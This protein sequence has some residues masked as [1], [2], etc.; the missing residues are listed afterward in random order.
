MI[1]FQHIIGR[2]ALFCR[3]IRNIMIIILII[4]AFFSLL[5]GDELAPAYP[6]SLQTVLEKRDSLAE[7][8][9]PDSILEQVSSDLFS[10]IERGRAYLKSG[11]LDDARA[12]FT[13]ALFSKSAWAKC[14]AHI[15]LG[16]CYRKMELHSLDAICEYRLAIQ[17]DST[18]CEAL[19]KLAMTQYRSIKA[20]TLSFCHPRESGGPE[21]LLKNLD[22]RF[23]GNDIVCPSRLK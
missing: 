1:I 2:N 4:S 22:S 3:L 20:T 18:S 14:Q 9:P 12:C 6:D 21:N 23:R 10:L 19:Y 17:T 7:A 11:N 15:G 5:A 16:D 13:P 8:L